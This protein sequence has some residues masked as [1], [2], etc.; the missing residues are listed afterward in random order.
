M[1]TKV[2]LLI[3]SQ[4]IRL[5]MRPVS[6]IIIICLPLAHDLDIT[7]LLSIIMALIALT[8]IWENVTSLMRGAKFW[9]KWENT[10]YPDDG[11]NGRTSSHEQTLSE[12][13]IRDS[14]LDRNDNAWLSIRV[15]RSGMAGRVQGETRD[16][17]LHW[18]S[19]AFLCEIYAKIEIKHCLQRTS[20]Y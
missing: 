9:E 5:L 6:A 20:T 14:K 17:S 4:P 13:N 19:L 1:S 12:K 16:Q 8:V 2:H 7:S 3:C 15:W 10:K 11:H 18:L